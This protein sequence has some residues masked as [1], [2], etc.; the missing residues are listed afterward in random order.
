MTRAFLT[1]IYRPCLICSIISQGMQKGCVKKTES[2][3]KVEKHSSTLV[4]QSHLKFADLN[5]LCGNIYRNI[6]DG[7]HILIW[8]NNTNVTHQG[9][10]K[11][12]S[13]L[14][15]AN[16]LWKWVDKNHV[17]LTAEFRISIQTCH[18]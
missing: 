8:T 3:R 2:V 18:M 16:K 13:M 12:Q 7:L 9:G 4:N 17:R 14:R 6:Y 11:S 1:S 10:T 5:V 15:W